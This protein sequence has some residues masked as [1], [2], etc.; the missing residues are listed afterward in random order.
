MSRRTEDKNAV[1]IKSLLLSIIFHASIILVIISI[2][3]SS[4]QRSKLMVI[5]FTIEDADNAVKG[6][7]LGSASK[8]KHRS[9]V[10]TMN[11]EVKR[12]QSEVRKHRVEIK[13]TKMESV[14]LPTHKI[15]HVA[16]TETQVPVVTDG[17]ETLR[18]I[19]RGITI[20]GGEDTSR[21]D[22]RETVGGSFAD[23]GG[24]G[25]MGTGMKEVS[26]G[27]NG[28]ADYGEKIRYLRANFIY[29]RDMIQKK[30]VYPT[31]ARKRGWEGKVTVSFVIF[32][33]GLTKN[34]RVMKSSSVEVLDRS[35]MEAVKDASPFPK[36]PAEA[37]I[38]IPI[39]YKLN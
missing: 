7:A 8:P 29:I 30:V 12:Q 32:S 17:D 26:G 14:P 3:N 2:N 16:S 31:I 22:Q 15:E 1:S 6:D 38:I 4:I 13:E 11:P 25:V 24:T 9:I 34:L 5:D 39:V 35:A 18:Y 36:P 21:N 28:K 27:E 37:Q 19:K 33:D 20:Q 23:G 10:R